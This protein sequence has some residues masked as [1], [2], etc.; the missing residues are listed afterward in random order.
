MLHSVRKPVKFS[1][2]VRNTNQ[3]TN[4]YYGDLGHQYPSK[5]ESLIV[6]LCTGQLASA[7]VSSSKTVGELIPAGVETVVLALR[8]GACVVK[9]RELLEEN[10][11][12]Q[13]WSVLVSG[14]REE[15]AQKLI[16]NFAR[17]NVSNY[18]N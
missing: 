18:L 7:A 11:P 9:V 16:E 1:C 12:S 2:G 15:E 14:I 5:S 13:S 6:G 4:S 10:G 17:A 8:L 3:G